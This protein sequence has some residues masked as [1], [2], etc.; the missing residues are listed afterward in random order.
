MLL[1]FVLAQLTIW[2]E[3]AARDRYMRNLFREGDTPPHAIIVAQRQQRPRLLDQHYY[4]VNGRV[5][6]P[7][8]Y[9]KPDQDDWGEYYGELGRMYEE[10]TQAV[11]NRTAQSFDEW[12]V[13]H[14][15]FVV[16]ENGPAGAHNIEQALQMNGDSVDIHMVGTSVGGTAIISYLSEAMRG[17]IPLDRRIR[18]VM[19]VD[20]PLGTRPPFAPANVVDGLMNGLQASSM[21]SD[22]AFGLGVWAEA[23]HVVI[24]TVDSRQDIV[25]F[26]PLPGVANDANPVY[27][28]DDAPPV[29]AYLKCNSVLCQLGNLA[30]FLDL[31]STWHI[32]TGSH[33]AISAREFIDEHWR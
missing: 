14:V 22:V 15:H 12:V 7:S 8:D 30:D 16:S 24:F 4:F 28:Q 21:R 17:E 10:A 13:E 19:I 2:S 3:E 1:P 31:G 5:A 25:G 9:S 18:S 20:S 33:M 26:D 27:L 6:A 11:S 23:S 32:Y 29:S